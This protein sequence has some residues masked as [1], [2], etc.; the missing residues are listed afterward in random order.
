MATQAL[1]EPAVTDTF[2][3]NGTDFIEL[4][5]GNARQRNVGWRLDY[6][7]ISEALVPQVR[8]VVIHGDIIGS[9]HCPVTLT[10]DA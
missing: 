6:F 9:D 1:P 8:D 3:I 2:P 4:Y 7:L 10:I 5:I